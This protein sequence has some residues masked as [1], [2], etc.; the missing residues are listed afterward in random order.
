VFTLSKQMVESWELIVG[1]QPNI[2]LE[3][4][5]LCEETVKADPRFQE[6]LARRGIT[7]LALVKV[8]A[9]SAGNYGAEEE[10]TRRILRTTVHVRL[11][12]EDVQ[13]NSYGHPIQGLHPIFDLGNLQVIRIEDYGEIPIPQPM[14]N[15]GIGTLPTRE[16]KPLSIE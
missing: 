1:V 11:N 14:G 7:N 5:A 9:W 15:Y 4:F 2:M 12:A 10:S 6:A 16:L 13:E 3:E 8:D